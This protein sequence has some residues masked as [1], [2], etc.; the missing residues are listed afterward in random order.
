MRK[1]VLSVLVVSLLASC[2]DDKTKTFTVS[3]VLKNTTAKFVYAEENDILKGKKEI[4]DSAVIA[5]DGKFSMKIKA[6]G[7]G[8]YNLRL[9]SDPSEFATVINDADKIEV[10]ADFKKQNDF[11]DVKGSKASKAIEDYFTKVTEM[12]SEKFNLFFKADSIRKNNGDSLLVENL[13]AKQLQLINDLKTYTQQMVRQANNTSLALF[14]LAT[15]QGM[16]LNQNYM[17]NAFTN[18]E[19]LAYLNEMLSRSPDRT[20]IAGV[21]NNVEAAIKKANQQAQRTMWVGKQAPELSLPDTEGRYVKLS[22]F[23]GK[24][25]LVDFWASWCAPCRRENPNVVQA[26]NQYRNKNFTILG[27]SLDRQKAAWE[28]AIVDDNLNWTH[29]SDLKYWQSEAVAIYQV[30]TI[31]FNVLIDPEGKVIA[32]NLRAEGLKQKLSEVL[33]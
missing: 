27:V 33:N 32:E 28:K 30:G 25:V 8:V 1:I 24:Y 23:K 15:Y 19:V 2:K 29:I 12:Q 14:I 17:L 3:G 13:T 21:R 22:S 7:E 18:P 16:A 26:Y 9:Q 11:Y 5:A 4:K 20:D 10:E 6:D 31:P